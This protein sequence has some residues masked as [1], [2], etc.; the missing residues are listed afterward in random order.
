M[1]DQVPS[2]ATMFAVRKLGEYDPP[3]ESA[4]RKIALR[5]WPKADPDNLDTIISLWRDQRRPLDF[6]SDALANSR[7]FRIL[8]VVVTATVG[9]LPMACPSKNKKV[10]GE[11]AQP[12]SG[13][14]ELTR[15]SRAR[16]HAAGARRTCAV[17]RSEDRIENQ[18]P[19]LLWDR[20]LAIRQ[21]VGNPH[22]VV[23]PF[24]AGHG[25]RDRVGFSRRVRSPNGEGACGRVPR[26]FWLQLPTRRRAES[27]Y[28]ERGSD[29]TIY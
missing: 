11:V 21:Q 23:L 20:W 9:R 10:E 22:W 7:R 12:H 19:L 16:R 13:R 14:D 2:A 27:E 24:P 5:L 8:M 15:G 26:F 17:L 1:T 18:P 25:S 28:R 29:L 4:A 6:V 3:S